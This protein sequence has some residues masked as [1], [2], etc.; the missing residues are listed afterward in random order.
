MADENSDV[1]P[2]TLIRVIGGEPTSEEVAAATAVVAG[3]LREGGLVDAPV[4]T[5]RWMV[6]ARA[7]RDELH[8]GTQKWDEFKSQ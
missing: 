5:D 8:R 6:S 4:P 2:L 3:M 1:D 7:G